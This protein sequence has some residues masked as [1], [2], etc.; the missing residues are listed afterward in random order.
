VQM[1]MGQLQTC[2]TRQNIGSS[3]RCGQ[4]S[5]GQ[6]EMGQGDTHHSTD[7]LV[8]LNVMATQRKERRVHSIG[9]GG[10]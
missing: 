10:A 7:D 8:W 1:G 2:S 3:R 4:Q 5:A 6:L 9:E